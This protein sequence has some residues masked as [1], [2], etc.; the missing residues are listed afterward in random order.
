MTQTNLCIL[1]EAITQHPHLMD[2]HPMVVHSPM[3]HT[4]LAPMP[5]CSQ[6]LGVLSQDSLMLVGFLPCLL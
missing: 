3:L 2:S 6:G 1:K 5:I 4:L